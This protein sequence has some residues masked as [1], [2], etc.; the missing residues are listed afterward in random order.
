[1]GEGEAL[2]GILC[3]RG[4]SRAEPNSMS[5]AELGKL[6]L[7]LDAVSLAFRQEDPNSFY[8]RFS[9]APRITHA[10]TT[11]PFYAEKGGLSGART[12]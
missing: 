5:N 2:G 12:S 10:G 6:K 11:P 3:S 1:M 9:S 8:R 4:F 7:A